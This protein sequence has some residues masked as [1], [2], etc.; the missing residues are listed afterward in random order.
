MCTSSC[1]VPCYA[2]S[3]I[4]HCDVSIAT[5]EV[6]SVPQIP[7]QDARAGKLK[8]EAALPNLYQSGA[9]KVHVPHSSE[10]CFSA[11]HMLCI[12]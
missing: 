1:S 3:D 8:A 2:K 9:L 11:S 10:L 12:I 7:G 5:N 6:L 4:Q